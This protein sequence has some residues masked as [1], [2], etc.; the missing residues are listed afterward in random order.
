[1][2]AIQ[3]H[4]RIKDLRDQAAKAAAEDRAEDAIRIGGQIDELNAQ[5]ED[6]L[7]L[8]DEARA[9]VTPVSEPSD[10]WRPADYAEAFLGPRAEFSGVRLVPEDGLA[11]VTNAVTGIPDP[12]RT[13]RDIP[14]IQQLATGFVDT[15]SKGRTDGDIRYMQAGEYTNA[16]AVWKTGNKPE[17]SYSW[18]EK[19]AHLAIIAHQTP[20]S[21]FALK[22][23]GQLESVIRNELLVGLR[24]AEDAAA[25]FANDTETGIVGVTQTATPYSKEVATDNLYDVIVKMK[26]KS[27]ADTGIAPTHV[28]VSPAVA[29]ALELLKTEG[30]E[31]LRLVQG[32][33]VAG[34]QVVED[35]NLSVT[36]EDETS[37][38]ILVYS[39]NAATWFTSEENEVLMGV[40]DKQFV[41]NQRTMLAEGEH[42]LKVT[43]PK[44]FVYMANALA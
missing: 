22:H 18:E 41:Q 34:L 7:R 15:L 25:L 28:A 16:A 38:G 31:Y 11:N 13:D 2:N 24:N 8:E 39:A 19:T 9:L 40:I 12:V 14:A 3:I 21:V 35:V 20:V 4:D 43:H 42:A 17:S 23:Y 27:L 44:S 5:L 33:R 1:M 29:T 32:G 26:A 36:V 6:A 10:E 37:E 30:G